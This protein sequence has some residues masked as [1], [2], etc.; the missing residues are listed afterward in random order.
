MKLYFHNPGHFELQAMLTFGVSAKNHSSPIGQF[1]T[2]FKY[3]VAIILRHGGSI[4]VR[5]VE[6]ETGKQQH[7]AFRIDKRSIRGKDFDM[8]VV[9]VMDG[10]SHQLV[11]A[12]FTTHLGVN[13]EPWMA[14]REL[15]SNAMD[16]HGGVATEYPEGEK[17]IIEVQCDPVLH[18]YHNRGDYFIDGTPVYVDKRWGV[19]VYPGPGKQL[20]FRGIAV[21][22]VGDPESTYRYNVLSR[23]DLSEERTARYRSQLIDPITRAL[24]ECTDAELLSCL[25]EDDGPCMEGR[26]HFNPYADES[27]E[28]LRV[29]KA[30]VKEL[31]TSIHAGYVNESI[32]R[33]VKVARDR[34]ADY[35]PYAPTA[36]ECASLKKALAFLA[37]LDID[38]GDTEI[39]PVQDMR[40]I[41]DMLSRVQQARIYIDRA[42]FDTGTK[43][44][45]AE[46]LWCW[47]ILQPQGDDNAT[48]TT[49]LINK[50]ISIGEA[51]GGEPL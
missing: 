29:C 23:V 48:N 17:T 37:R 12:G 49:C 2:G 34:A 1:G 8:V 32:A 35:L 24:Q 38:F 13:W 33:V 45:A 39:V 47:S 31:H 5:T 14:F 44:L 46:L 50:L 30:A 6:P 9:S 25:R 21:A 10:E 20:Y 7:Y 27:T 41:S 3:A 51:M 28:F 40:K 18:A 22:P 16:E 15:Y 42:A 26:L 19:E 4:D 36:I 11:D 43:A